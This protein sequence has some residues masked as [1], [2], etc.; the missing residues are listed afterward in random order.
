MKLLLLRLMQ[1]MHFHIHFL[2]LSES[3][4]LDPG[5]TRQDW[6]ILRNSVT[7][8][9]PEIC[10]LHTPQHPALRRQRP[11]QT[12]P[13]THAGTQPHGA[14]RPAVQ[15]PVPSFFIP[16]IFSFAKKPLVPSLV[17]CK[18]P[19][20]IPSTF[21]RKPKRVIFIFEKFLNIFSFYECS[22]C[23]VSFFVCYR[24]VA[25]FHLFFSFSAASID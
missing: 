21:K 10:P 7:S 1:A 3:T 16:L 9:T 17:P 2:P 4:R 15:F 14:A 25:Y 6:H 20:F 11:C 19:H 13:Q 12:Q 18:A 5:I 8:T 23:C 22:P 24:N